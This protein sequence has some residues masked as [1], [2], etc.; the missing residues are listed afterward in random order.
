MNTI[1]ECVN[2]CVLLGIHIPKDFSDK[3][4]FHTVH[5]FN[6][7]CNELRYDFKLLP[8][9]V[10]SQ[11]FS[12]FCLDA[13]GSQLWNFDSK[14]VEPYYFS[15]RKTKMVRLLWN[16]SRTPHCDCLSTINHSLP[17]DIALEKMCTHIFWASVNSE[18]KVVKMV[19]FFP[20]KA[21]RSVLGDIY[22]YLSH[23]YSI[24]L[25]DRFGSYNALNGCINNLITQF[26]DCS[27]YTYI[28][29]DFCYFR[30]YAEIFV[31][32]STEIVQ[33][34]EYLCTI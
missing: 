33:I 7:K 32:T 1:I 26:V 12:S 9:D 21:A 11:L 29:R 10:K 34:I 3:N 23:K 8:S 5:K 28:V 16:L 17:L 31:L 24:Y 30:D 2:E 13:Y 4:V 27:Q 15:W 14:M 22:R 6:R 19:T 18:N 20:I 25:N